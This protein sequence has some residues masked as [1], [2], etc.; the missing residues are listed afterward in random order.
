MFRRQMERE[1]LGRG[2]ECVLFI[3]AQAQFLQMLCGLDRLLLV[4]LLSSFPVCF[5]Y[6]LWQKI[7]CMCSLCKPPYFSRD[8]VW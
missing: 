1:E 4:V 8:L 3:H 2:K 7:V 5:S 6:Q